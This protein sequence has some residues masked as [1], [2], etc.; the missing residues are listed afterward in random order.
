MVPMGEIAMAHLRC[1]GG[2]MTGPT[3]EQ[4]QLAKQVLADVAELH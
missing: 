2:Q 4:T 3:Q 1:K